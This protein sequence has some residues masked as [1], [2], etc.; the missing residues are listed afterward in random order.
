MTNRERIQ[1]IIAGK[2]PDRF[3]FG[4]ADNVMPETKF[5]CLVRISEMLNE[6]SSR[7]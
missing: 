2:K 3:I 1:A 4:V 7:A 6:W 5:E